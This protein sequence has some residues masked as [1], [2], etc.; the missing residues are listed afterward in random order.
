VSYRPVIKLR[1]GR[2]AL[3]VGAIIRETDEDVAAAARA[4]RSVVRDGRFEIVYAAAPRWRASYPGLADL[5]RAIDA[6]ENWRLP[7]A[8]KRR[9]RGLWRDGDTLEVTRPFSVTVLRK[10]AMAGRATAR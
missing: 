2:R 6:S 10:R 9:I 7:A 4:V 5:E 8:T 3:D 1:R